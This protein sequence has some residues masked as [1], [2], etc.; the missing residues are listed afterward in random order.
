MTRNPRASEIL[1]RCLPGM[2]TYRQIVNTRYLEINWWRGY[3]RWVNSA[4]INRRSA[5]LMIGPLEV[6]VGRL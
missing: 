4:G 6:N 1:R 3:V 2:P 5:Y